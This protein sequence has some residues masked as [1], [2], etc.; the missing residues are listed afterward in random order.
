MPPKGLSSW[1]EIRC[2]RKTSDT[3]RPCKSP[4]ESKFFLVEK[5]SYCGFGCCHGS[6]Y[7]HPEL[8]SS[9]LHCLGL[10]LKASSTRIGMKWFR[11]KFCVSDWG[12]SASGAAVLHPRALSRL[13]ERQEPGVALPSLLGTAAPCKWTSTIPST[14]ATK[15][16]WQKGI[17]LY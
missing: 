7:P 4:A 13:W 15:T 16:G 9:F 3:N 17:F 5:E 8:S 14:E 10:P 2:Q 6:K 12:D 1:K 11:T